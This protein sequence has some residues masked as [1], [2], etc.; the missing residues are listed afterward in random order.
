LGDLN[1]FLALAL[2]L[3][4]RGHRPVIATSAIHED[5]V[6]RTG[7]DFH[8][9]RPDLDS[10]DRALIHRAMHPRHGT[11]VIMRDVIFPSIRNTYADLTRLLKDDD[12]L[13]THSISY[14]AHI[15]AAKRRLKWIS[16]VI[17]PIVFLSAYDMPVLPG[18]RMPPFWEKLGP[19]ANRLLIAV[20]KRLT[21]H[22]C[23]PVLR[24][25]ADLGLNSG[26]HPLFEGQF[27]PALVLAMFSE[28]LAR[29]QPDWPPNTCLAGYG[30]QDGRTEL[31][32]VSPELERFLS[33]GP[34]PV[35]FALGS[36]AVY[37]AGDFFHRAIAA[38]ATLGRRAVLVV[39]NDTDN[40]PAGDLPCDVIAVPYAPYS[41]LFARA[42][43]IVHH[44]GA[45][46]TGQA[47]R[48]GKPMLVVP[49][50][51]DQPDN[52][53]RLERLGL[54]KT[55]PAESCSHGDLSRS[56][57]ALAT[58]PAYRK[59]AEEV[60]RRVRPRNGISNACDAVEN[61]LA[62]TAISPERMTAA[63]GSHHP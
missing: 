35:V 28:V 12:I 30:H 20:I 37:A 13:I 21:L 53:R 44:G 31:S 17:S 5:T 60:G 11:E 3:Q 8:P 40:L 43:V 46:T 39:G 55:L 47:L 24:L 51:H 56:I 9:L 38:A 33:D 52:A 29:P 4:N 48:A 58:A 7:V 10:S 45:G 41:K 36:V 49:F 22:W 54:S 50:A 27:S 6:R 42:D 15:I 2:G 26:R 25:R 32:D 34:P 14:A 23:R 1:P 18:I 59:R 16:V 62:Q 57:A 19:P 61:F 63:M